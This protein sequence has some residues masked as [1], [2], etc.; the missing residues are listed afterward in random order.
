MA[1]FVLA[2]TYRYFWPVIVNVP[3]PA[4]AG[5]TLEQTFDVEFEALSLDE[6][7]AMDAEYAALETARDR[8]AHQHD[9]LKRAVKGWRGVQAP[10]GSDVPFTEKNFALALQHAWFRQ[11]VYRAYSQSVSGEARTGN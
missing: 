8:A 3:D 9:F 10:G 6:A 11:G 5:K 1:Q 7:T 2:E 4:E